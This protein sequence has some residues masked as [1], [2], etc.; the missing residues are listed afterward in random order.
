M[1]LGWSPFFEQQLVPHERGDFRVARIVE[2]Q[3][4]L[5]SVAGEFD[6]RA[7]ISGR[8]RHDRPSPSELPVV[9][10]WVLIAPGASGGRA[11][12]H[13]R[14]P[15]RSVV[16]RKAAGRAMDEQVIAANVDALFLVTWRI[17]PMSRLSKSP[18]S[19][20]GYR[21]STSSWWRRS[22]TAASILCCRI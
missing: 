12:I 11:V 13:D 21:S 9:G 5:Y 18:R 3:R 16:S 19:A 20:L 1:R 17:S 10:D 6:G 15:R 8:L 4:G 22:A 14:L 2:Q 7:E